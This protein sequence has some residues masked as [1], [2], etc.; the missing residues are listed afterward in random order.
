M[1]TR[2]C[3]KAGQNVATAVGDPTKRKS[4]KQ[5]HVPLAGLNKAGNEPSQTALSSRKRL[6][7]QRYVYHPARSGTP[8]WLTLHPFNHLRLLIVA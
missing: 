6:S 4:H 7:E 5:L 2:R 3:P 1:S 8:Y